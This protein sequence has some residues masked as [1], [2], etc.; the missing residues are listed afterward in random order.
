MGIYA[1]YCHMGYESI[2]SVVCENGKLVENNVFEEENEDYGYYN[3]KPI[4]QLE[5]PIETRLLNEEYGNR[6]YY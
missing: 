2:N 3:G 5:V 1:D 4:E 6:F